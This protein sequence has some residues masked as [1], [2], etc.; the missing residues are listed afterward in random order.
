M[1]MKRIVWNVEEADFLKIPH[2]EKFRNLNGLKMIYEN[3]NIF[4]RILEKFNLKY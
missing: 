3:Y 1:F 2:D 4:K